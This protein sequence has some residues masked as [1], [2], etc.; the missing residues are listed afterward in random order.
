MQAGPSAGLI[1]TARQIAAAEGL[2]GF[3]R[4]ALPPLVAL[5]VLNSINFSC[6]AYFRAGVDWLAPPAARAEQAA[7]VLHTETWRAAAAGMCIAP[8]TSIISTPFERVKVYLQLSPPGAFAGPAQCAAAMLRRGGLRDLYVGHGINMARE[9]IFISVYF[10]IW[11]AARAQLLGVS[12]LAPEAA[13]PLAGGLAGAAAW[14]ASTPADAVKTVLQSPH[15][16]HE[17]ARPLG[18]LAVLRQI[19]RER[20]VAGLYSGL[21]PSV[22]RA[23]VVSSSRFCVYEAVMASMLPPPPGGA[24][25]FC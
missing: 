5:T 3:Y 14:A 15:Q 24:S 4:G 2:A 17:A 16:P 22:L 13:I 6:Y 10:S 8:F 21:L 18:A 1:A 23:A 9:A 20:G 19:L 25:A 7:Q 11:E 12:G